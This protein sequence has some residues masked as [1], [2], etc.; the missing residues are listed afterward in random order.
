MTVKRVS[1]AERA[2]NFARSTRKYPQSY[3]TITGN[4]GETKRFSLQKVR[5][6]SKLRLLVT[7]TLTATH[8][9]ATS[10]TP[11]LLAPYTLLRAL[12]VTTNMSYTPWLSS[13]V[14]AYMKMFPRLFADQILPVYPTTAAPGTDAE[15]RAWAYQGKAAASG[16]GAA[17][18][19]AFVVD[20]PFTVNDRDPI[21]LILTQN[22]ETQVDVEFDLGTAADL[23]GA[24]QTPTFTLSAISVTPFVEAF[25]VP[26]DP[27][28]I[29]D[30]TVIKQ[31]AE[32]NYTTTAGR[33]EYLLPTGATYRNIMFYVTDAT[34]NPVD[35]TSFTGNFEFV[36]NGSDIPYRIPAPI[37]SRMAT[38]QL[39]CPLPKGMFMLDF[40]SQG[41]INYGG[42]RDLVDTERLTDLRLVTSHGSPLNVKVVYETLSRMGG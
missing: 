37:L 9:S 24:A 19:I 33:Y 42:T 7:A 13:G 38:E 14:G 34:G 6:T 2:Q 18:Q 22:Q 16:G 41:L 30:L 4:A 11:A 3:P 27:N 10:Y 12:R 20:V 23:V 36:F 35:D 25:S 15:K 5:L 31:V 21:G 32:Q 39:G 26:V 40:S 8:A 29:P 28:A 1:P 17:N